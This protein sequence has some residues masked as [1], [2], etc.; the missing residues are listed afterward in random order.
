MSP[1]IEPLTAD[2]LDDEAQAALVAG[3][4]R[5][6]D[7]YLTGSPDAPPLP[8]VL[9]L[10]LNHPKLAAPWFKFNNVLLYEPAIDP[11][12]RE[13]MILRVAWRARGTYEWLQHVRLA[14]QLGVTNDELEALTV[15]ADAGSWS[16]VEA[17]LLRAVDELFDDSRIG[18]A[19]WARLS[20]HF[21]TRQLMEITFVIGSYLCLAFVFNSADLPLDPGLDPGDIPVPVREG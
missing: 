15:G 2:K 19:T 12:Q 3:F 9:G 18:D 13:L 4:P 1:R 8:T 20:Q 16:P 5:A 6:A 11:R 10:L 17:D 7:Q 21:D 14:Q